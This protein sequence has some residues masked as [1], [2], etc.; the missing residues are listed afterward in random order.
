MLGSCST[1]WWKLNL[2]HF[3]VPLLIL[4]FHLSAE[5]FILGYVTRRH[6][7]LHCRLPIHRHAHHKFDLCL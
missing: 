3:G 2:G 4:G 6:L 7:V 5:E 1:R